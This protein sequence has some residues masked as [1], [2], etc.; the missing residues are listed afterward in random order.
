MLNAS[1]SKDKQDNVS[2]ISANPFPYLG[3]GFLLNSGGE[4]EYQVYQKPNQK[5]KYLNKGSTRT[6]AMF[7]AI[8]GGIF[9]RLVKLTSIAKKNAQ[10]RIEKKTSRTLQG[11]NQSRPVSKYISNSDI[12]L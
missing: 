4:L 5:L 8:P 11:V 10:T 6:N 12:N 1:P 9:N 7:N 3:L 2:E